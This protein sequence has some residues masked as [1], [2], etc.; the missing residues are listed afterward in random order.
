MPLFMVQRFGT[1]KVGYSFAPI[2]CLWY[3][4]NGGIGIYSNKFDWMVVKTINPKYIIDYFIR[5]KKQAWISL[6]GILLTITGFNMNN[7]R[8]E[9]CVLLHWF[10]NNHKDVIKSLRYM[11]QFRLIENNYIF[12]I[13]LTSRH[14]VLRMPFSPSQF[15]LVVIIT[16]KLLS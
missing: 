12:S 11:V 2:I 5:N 1:D 16:A 9:T 6:G 13:K 8:S 7:N 15:I 14:N 3:A 4:L 10:L